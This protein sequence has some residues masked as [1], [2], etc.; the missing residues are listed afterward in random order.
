MTGAYVSKRF[1]IAT[2]FTFVMTIF[3]NILKNG[4]EEIKINRFKIVKNGQKV[5]ERGEIRADKQTKW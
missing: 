1:C 3:W 2:H 5:F 4:I